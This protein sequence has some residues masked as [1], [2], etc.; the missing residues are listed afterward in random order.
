MAVES[1]LFKA[2][3]GL[4]HEPNVRSAIER[5]L[6]LS[7][8]HTASDLGFIEITKPARERICSHASQLDDSIRTWSTNIIKEV[9][10]TRK[11]VCTVA[12]DDERFRNLDS[13]KR[14]AIEAV[15]VAPLPLPLEG[16]VYLQRAPGHPLYTTADQ[17]AI[18]FV[19]RELADVALALLGKRTLRDLV[20]AATR[21]AVVDALHVHEGNVTTAAEQLDIGRTT[22]YR[23]AH[24]L[25]IE[26]DRNDD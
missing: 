5:V 16:V 11:I 6:S 22:L 21:S 15:L 7:L 8:Q 20:A 9:L 17:E 14:H 1:D 13:V 18:E 23:H 24:K 26:I 12:V 10:S 25:G 4:R 2:L 19:A 3:L